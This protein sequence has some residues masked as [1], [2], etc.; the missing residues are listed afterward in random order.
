MM[1]FGFNMNKQFN[2]LLF[3]ALFFSSCGV[4]QSTPKK[5]KNRI[6]GTTYVKLIPEQVQDVVLEGFDIDIAY[7]VDSSLIFS[8]YTDGDLTTSDSPVNWGDRLVQMKKGKV[9]FQSKPVGDPYEYTPS[10]FQ[11]PNNGKIVIICQLGNEDHYGGEVFILENGDIHFIGMIEVEN[12]YDLP[13][14]NSLIDIIQIT[15]YNS[16]IYFEFN[17]D[18]L[19]YL[20][21]NDWKEVIND[22]VYYKYANDKFELIGL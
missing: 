16:S 19:T 15:E 1:S 5:T 18:T 10:F 11:N 13:N 8:A 6:D 3:V 21:N 17:S 4:S 9:I 7:Q 14:N 22:G 20:G 12:P 2:L